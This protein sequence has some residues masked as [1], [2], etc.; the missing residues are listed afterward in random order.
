[1]D[2]SGADE[3]DNT[4]VGFDIE[5]NNLNTKNT[6]NYLLWY[7]ESIPYIA[8]K[9]PANFK[10]RSSSMFIETMNSQDM[11]RNYNNET[12]FCFDGL[13]RVS[14]PSETSTCL[15]ISSDEHM[16]SN[17]NAICFIHT[18]EYVFQQ[19]DYTFHVSHQSFM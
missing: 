3:D 18:E 9:T 11:S 8:A 16:Y 1:M 10:Y 14:S 6:S 7:L 4:N 17:G 19:I 12:E 15:T 5:D 2:A 13:E